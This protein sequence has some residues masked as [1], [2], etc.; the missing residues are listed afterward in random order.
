MKKFYLEQDNYVALT[1]LS[2]IFKT[3]NEWLAST[4]SLYFKHWI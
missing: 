1:K 3:P 2:L 4:F